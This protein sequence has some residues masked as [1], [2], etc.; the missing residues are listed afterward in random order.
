MTAKKKTKRGRRD[1]RTPAEHMADVAAATLARHGRL[2]NELEYLSHQLKM[3]GD[4]IH[5]TDMDL[6]H[7]L[8]EVAAGA[9]A[10][11]CQCVRDMVE[12][13]AAGLPDRARRLRA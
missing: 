13:V 5:D 4:Y 12:T 10:V 11:G 2:R 7:Q 6:A 1:T 8:M 3:L 9:D